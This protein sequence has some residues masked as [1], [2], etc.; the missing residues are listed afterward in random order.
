[1]RPMTITMIQRLNKGTPLNATVL[2]RALAGVAGGPN[3]GGLSGKSFNQ[4]P[5]LIFRQ[6]SSQMPAANAE[7]PVF[8]APRPA[9][10]L[11]VQGYSSGG[12]W[13]VKLN[14]DTYH[15]E[16]TDL[17]TYANTDSPNKLFL[18]L[19]KNGYVNTGDKIKLKVVA[20]SSVADFQFVVFLRLLA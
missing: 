4:S 20:A 16:D 15:N 13:T 11:G 2:N 14:T 17:I 19:E 7:F 18:P 9:T 1:M 8:F 5:L 12:T 10:I 3:V 6:E